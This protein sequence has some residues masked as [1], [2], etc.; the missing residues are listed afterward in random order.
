MNKNNKVIKISPFHGGKCIEVFNVND[1][2]EPLGNVSL[3]CFVECGETEKQAV[4]N[5]LEEFK[6]P[7]GASWES[8]EEYCQQF[9]EVEWL[10]KFYGVS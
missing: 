3:S 7:F 1:N 9:D 10:A 6:H 5:L 8:P 2:G 4:K